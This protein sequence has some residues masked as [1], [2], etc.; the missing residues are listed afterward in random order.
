MP[1]LV[2]LK[3]LKLINKLTGVRLTNIFGASSSFVIFSKYG[4]GGGITKKFQPQT[5]T[6]GTF[7]FQAS[8]IGMAQ[9][10]VSSL[11]LSKMVAK[12]I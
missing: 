4:S 8:D 9:T 5:P 10:E 1:P 12:R 2:I 7:I 11:I 6:V 3:K